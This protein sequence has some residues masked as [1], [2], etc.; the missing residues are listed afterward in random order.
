MNLDQTLISSLAQAVGLGLGVALILWL[1][2]RFSFTRRVWLSVLG[3][4]LAVGLATVLRAAQVP[5]D[6]VSVRIATAIAI[7]LAANAVLQLLNSLVWGYL[8]VRLRHVVVPRLLVDLFNVVILLAV[9]LAVLDRVF[10][11]DLTALLVTSTVASAVIGLSLQ[12]T[13][14]NVIAG[15]ALQMDRPF[16]VG[17][18]VNIAGQDGE[19]MQTNW[20]TITLRSIDNH[21]FVIP[22]AN[23]ARHDIINY[24]QPTLLQR[25]H[26][27]VGLSYTYPPGEVKRVLLQAVTQADGVCVEPAPDILTSAYADFAI[28]YDIRY[29]I[30]D[31]AKHPEIRDAV[32]TRIWYAIR[33]EGMSVPF[34]IRDVNLRHVPEDQELQQRARIRQDVFVHLRSL[35]LFAP[36]SDEQIEELAHQARVERYTKGEVLVRQGDEGDSLFV[37]KSGRVQV[38]L[39]GEDGH[40]MT[41]AHR[42]EDEFFGEM[43][44]LTGERRS[45]SVIAESETEV[46]IVHKSAMAE[47]LA[48]DLATLEA[49]SKEVEQRQREAAAKLAAATESRPGKAAAQE[50]N[51]LSRIQGFLGLK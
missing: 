3:M 12:D 21:R 47:V 43:S 7:M 15:V 5:S 51:L 28:T 25:L 49:L 30:K 32:L 9:A 4:T 26:V 45:A 35:T 24:S 36:L 6:D 34:P 39:Q 16:S 23:V 22:N 20:R 33:R 27:N 8:I 31:Y 42:V 14:G 29:W 41:V 1:L 40:V 50:S 48:A 2:R 46:V 19:V 18:W 13:L 37:V 44:L 11:V 38:D 17:D 10:A